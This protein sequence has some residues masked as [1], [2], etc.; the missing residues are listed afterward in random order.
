M[1]PPHPAARLA[2]SSPLPLPVLL[3]RSGSVPG[4][5]SLAFT[6]TARDAVRSAKMV[7]SQTKQHMSPDIDC[8]A[9]T[10]QHG[11]Q[12]HG[13]TGPH[14]SATCANPLTSR[15]A[16]ERGNE[17]RCARARGVPDAGLLESGDNPS[18]S[19]ISSEEQYI[20][21][22]NQL[23]ALAQRRGYPRDAST[24]RS[25]EALADQIATTLHQCCPLEPPAAL[26]S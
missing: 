11:Q 24:A 10:A 19:F 14:N 4:R 9:C 2:M 16:H 12:R 5:A 26:T 7:K 15:Y 21:C 1:R 17:S 23:A 18:A 6:Q 25:A 13:H 3:Q 8:G 20:L 22:C